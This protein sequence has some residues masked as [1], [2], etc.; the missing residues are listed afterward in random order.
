MPYPLHVRKAPTTWADYVTA[1]REATGFGDTEMG[2]VLDV[3][4]ATVW[5]WRT[6]KQKRPENADIVRRF[7]EKFGLDLDEALAAAG[8]RP[9]VEPPAEPTREVDEEVELIMRSKVS[10]AM[11]KRMLARLEELR[12]RD[13]QQR[14]EDISWWLERGA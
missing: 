8:M 14:M 11:K 4:P 12:Q 6:G 1:I 9:G 3:N 10:D 2:R 13:K 5:R 7:A